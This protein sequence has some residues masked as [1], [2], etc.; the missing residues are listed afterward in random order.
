V[1]S[2]AHPP[3]SPAVEPGSAPFIGAAL[4]AGLLAAA[5]ALLVFVSLGYQV[6]SGAPTGV[7]LTVRTW[8]HSLETPRLTDAMW[9]ASYYGAPVRLLP[10]GLAAAAVF[11]IR[12]WRR[13]AV[14]VL[15][16]IAGAGVLNLGLKTLFGRA[17]PEAFFDQYPVPE[18]FSFPSGHALFAACFFGGIAVL[19]S[20]RLNSWVAEI[21]VWLACVF[22]ILLIGVSRIYLGVHYPT[23]VIGGFAVGIVWV[24]SVALGDRLAERRRRLRV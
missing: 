11:Q 24:M 5:V 17:R 2:G 10:L 16:A 12:R 21:V 8:V 4:A 22:L 20:H 9:A 19:A 23:D 13:G 14:L 3:E 6:R 7:D 18:S 15:V 1:T